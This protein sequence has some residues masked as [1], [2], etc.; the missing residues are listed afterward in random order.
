[1]KKT[2]IAVAVAS[3]LGASAA[4]A[5]TWE[6][7][8]MT[9][10]SA[11]GSANLTLSGNLM[12]QTGPGNSL[13]SDGAFSGQAFVGVTPL[14][15]HT[16]GAG[17]TMSGGGTVSGSF[18]CL[19]GVFGGIVGASICGNYNFGAN[20][21]NEST[22][23]TDGSN[24][25][26]GGDDKAIGPAQSVADFAGFVPNIPPS[27]FMSIIQ[28][29]NGTAT[30]GQIWTFQAVVPVPAAVWLFGSALGLLGWVRRRS[31]V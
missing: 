14:Y 24:R 5:A 12:F 9:T 8:G 11:N 31:A 1:M 18:N 28:L 23:N 29:E 22:V 13:V 26:L 19:E 15:T 30:Q 20:Y 17:T 7:I 21:T 27:D 2:A 6:L 10:K 16:W 4:S 25:V 3:A